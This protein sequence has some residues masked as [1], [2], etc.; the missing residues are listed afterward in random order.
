MS[1]DIRRNLQGM[2]SRIIREL[3][4]NSLPGYILFVYSITTNCDK[5]FLFVVY[6]YYTIRIIERRISIDQLTNQEEFITSLAI[7]A[8]FS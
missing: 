7:E 6:K 1:G 3:T 8:L 2:F 5:Y 4:G